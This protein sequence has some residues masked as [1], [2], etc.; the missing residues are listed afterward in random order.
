MMAAHQLDRTSTVIVQ[1]ARYHLTASAPTL[2]GAQSFATLAYVATASLRH[3]L[4][5]NLK[6]SQ[7]TAT[8]AT[9]ATTSATAVA[10]TS[11]PTFYGLV[12]Y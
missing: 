6:V 8:I 3:W 7:S 5:Y 10:T 2:D 9:I 12:N 1:A 4:C 11:L